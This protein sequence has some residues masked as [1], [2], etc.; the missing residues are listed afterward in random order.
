MSKK[1]SLVFLSALLFLCCGNSQP[2]MAE[3]IAAV[4]FTYQL[5]IQRPL[6][7]RE[8]LICFVSINNQMDPSITLL[9]QLRKRGLEVKP[10]SQSLMKNGEVQDKATGASGLRLRV[11]DIQFTSYDNCTA[12]GSINSSVD[13]LAGWK[14]QLIREKGKWKVKAVELI[15]ES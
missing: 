8:R 13:D 5:T 14:Y 11:F 9:A 12:K 6:R 10:T 2:D 7:D 1:L 4:V 15:V 3:D